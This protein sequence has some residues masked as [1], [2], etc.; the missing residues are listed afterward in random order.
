MCS[1]ADCE[2]YS[3]LCLAWFL[4]GTCSYE[5]TLF[6]NSSLL[7]WVPGWLPLSAMNYVADMLTMPRMRV[8]EVAT[9]YT[10]FNRCEIP[11][12]SIILIIYLV[13]VLQGLLKQVILSV[14][15]VW[16]HVYSSKGHVN[17]YNIIPLHIFLQAIQHI[18][19]FSSF[20]CPLDKCISI[21]FSCPVL[22]KTRVSSF[23][24]LYISNCILFPLHYG[25][26]NL[27]LHSSAGKCSCYDF[28]N[29]REWK[30][31]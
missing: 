25:P 31:E 17:I 15:Q 27:L 30:L 19:S 2:T 20:T 7:F 21:Y 29:P 5:A 28:W 4:W 23:V 10:M 8:Y 18:C 6:Y 9:F 16:V 3:S 24:S 14:G 13:C 11:Q 26:P 1:F 12:L 22:E